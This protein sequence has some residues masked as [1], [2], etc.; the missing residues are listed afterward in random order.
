MDRRVRAAFESGAA[1]CIEGGGS[2]RFFGR[3]PT[4]E[5][6]PVSDHRGI[7]N[8]EPSELVLTVR[9]GTPVSETQAAL[10]TFETDLAGE[11]FVPGLYRILV[12]WPGFLAH[13]SASLAPLLRDPGVLDTCEGIAERIAAVAPS[14]LAVLETSAEPAPLAP[15]EAAAVLSAI[16]T[17]RGTSPQMIGF[18]TLI[19]QA[20]PAD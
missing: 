8:H 7:V 3:T 18:G 20:L 5:P 9:S 17:Y 14:V 1:L 2:K 12:H 11:A 16:R 13:L 6:L 15:G 4:G 10:A 19:L